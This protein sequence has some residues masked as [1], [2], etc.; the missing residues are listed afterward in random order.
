MESN[1]YT[2]KPPIKSLSSTTQIV[3]V[4][5]GIIVF[6][7][8][9]PSYLWMIEDIVR[10]VC[11]IIVF[12]ICLTNISKGQHTKAILLLLCLAY[13]W[14]VIVVDRSGVIT[15]L[16]FI[17]FAFIPV[18]NKNLVY[19]AYHVF[20][21]IF[22]VFLL[23]GILNY[24][25]F[26]LG[27]VSSFD[28]IEPLNSLKDHKYQQY[29][30]MVVPDVPLQAGKLARFHGLFDEP[31]MLGNICGLILIAEKMQ[32]NRRGNLII[33]A[34]GLLSL[35]FF[36]YVALGLSFLLFSKK[37]K[38]RYIWIAI[39]L[40][41][42]V[43]TYNVKPLYDTLWHRFEWDASEGKFVGDNRNGMG[44]DDLYESLKWTPAFFS[45][46]GSNFMKDYAGAASLKLVIL[47]HGMIFVLLNLSAYALLAFREIKKKWECIMFM[48][49]FIMM[50]Y[51]RPGF[52]NTSS[53][54]LYTMLIYMYGSS[55][56]AQITNNGK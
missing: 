56:Q 10:P 36:F 8:C 53:I 2:V 54:F 13:A 51:Q 29:L 48:A 24:V 32:L 19:E 23:L 39:A 30:F 46:L 3:G 52:Y 50:L 9:M 55:S 1:Y 14:A 43:T 42:V 4:I 11:A 15:F 44:L 28:I 41:F 5:L 27:I 35:S 21:V 38:H 33:L 31:G 37:L 18:L 6:I 7:R 12:L 16:N 25:F 40:S 22:I 34:G 49:F 20:R 17:A 45:G 47:K 26:L